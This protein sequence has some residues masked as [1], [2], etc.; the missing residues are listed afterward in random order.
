MHGRECITVSF[1]VMSCFDLEF[2]HIGC[3]MSRGM[4]MHRLEAVIHAGS[5]PIAAVERNCLGAYNRLKATCMF[6]L[7]GA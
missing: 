5:H 2:S 1:W 6:V 3:F 4:K 7:K